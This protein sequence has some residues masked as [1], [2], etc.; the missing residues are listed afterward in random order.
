M[1]N[2]IFSQNIAELTPIP[3]FVRQ[4]AAVEPA[5]SV[6][7]RDH[8]SGRPELSD[9]PRLADQRKCRGMPGD[10]G[11]TPR[12]PRKE[13]EKPPLR[14]ETLPIEDTAVQDDKAQARNGDG[15]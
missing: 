13:S 10:P 11:M 1:S 8:D 6:A 2:P 14:Q 12:S 3:D 9:S 7:L 15:R 4:R 5:H